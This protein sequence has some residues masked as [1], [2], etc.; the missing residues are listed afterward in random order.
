VAIRA[1]HWCVLG[2][3]TALA[4]ATLAQDTAGHPASGEAAPADETAA[5]DDKRHETRARNDRW[6]EE[7]GDPGAAPAGSGDAVAGSEPAAGDAAAEAPLPT[8]PVDVAEDTSVP[9]E[10]GST[11]L[12]DIMVTSQ[13]RV[14]SIQDVPIS[15]TALTGQ[16]LY[17]Q[18]V[19]D[20][21]EALQ[22]TP[23]ARVDAAGFFS[24]PRVRGFTLNNNNKSFE[25]PVGMVFDG[26]P[27]ARVEYFLAALMDTA[28]MEVM[29]GPQGTTFGKNTTAGLIHL[30]AN[31]PTSTPQGSLQIEGG[32]LDRRHIQAAYGGPL[33]EGLNFRVAALLDERAG[34]IENTSAPLIA[35]AP[36]AFKDRK[37]TGVR[38]ITEA[39]D[40]W[41][42]RLLLAFESFEMYDGGAAL[43][44]ISSGPNF[45]NAVRNY[46]PNADFVPGNWIHS[47]D[48]RDFKD[49]SIRKGRF[50]LERAVGDWEFVALGAHAVMRQALELD[51]DF[52][53][54]RAIPGF[55]T[56][57]SPE[58]YGEFRVTAPTADGLLGL[59]FL[60]GTSDLLFGVSGGRRQILDSH[61]IFGVNNGPF[62]DLVAAAGADVG[63]SP[64]PGDTGGLIGAPAIGGGA[65]D[66]LDQRFSQDAQELSGFAHLQYH[67]LPKW[68]LELG[69]R[70]TTEKK[71]AAWDLVFTT[72]TSTTLQAI[73]AEE[74]TATRS[75]DMQNFQ[76]KVSLGWTPL[77]DLSLFAH[78]EKG[79]KA[80]GFNAFALRE[81]V[82]ESGVAND[83]ND[84][85]CQGSPSDPTTPAFMDDDLVFRDEVATNIGVDIKTWLFDRTLNLNL[86]LFRQV[87]ED[88]QVLIRENPN[89]TVGLGT[90]RVVNAE[91]ALAE[92]I[93]ADLRWRVTD[94]LNAMA[95]VGVLRTEFIR[96]TKGECPVGNSKK[97]S[98][99]DGDPACAQHGKPFPFAPQLGA[100]VSL[101]LN[102][103][104]GGLPLVGS[105]LGG[106]GFVAGVLAEYEDTQLLDVD[107][108]ERKRQDAYTRYRADFGITSLPQRWTL[109]VVGENLTDTVTWVRMGD[110]FED[111]VVGSQNQPRLVYLQFR[112]DF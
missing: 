11:Q 74:F 99:Q 14:Q 27:H 92:G 47:Q 12:D 68:H 65:Y 20:V 58:T 86:S 85:D 23:N 34:F 77:R 82:C 55:G 13:K 5:P 98:D 100:T 26:I 89:G 76:P 67:F 1:K 80:G 87:A 35:G 33:T 28:R 41:G 107:L 108:D 24:A 78:W 50:Q 103:P 8:V 64:S 72:E 2:L 19:T 102:L 63:G 18:A 71:D 62:A 45:Q 59:S 57:H 21:R 109:R 39:P 48:Q 43:E 110:V 15:V 7:G 95:G 51:T 66:E 94:W 101:R 17:E 29:R 90:S 38:L 60:P 106:L 16:M 42:S 54:A 4:P 36:D 32:E 37:R 97:D 93:E 105:S 88:F 81:G 75:L 73:G 70:Y 91:E 112:Q 3:L 9:A 53:P 40:L 46:D 31:E 56:D 79:Y 111:V 6:W 30:I 83:P 22:L 84:P 49:V 69:G 61:F 104:M 10:A 44:A 25:P 52:T 96:F